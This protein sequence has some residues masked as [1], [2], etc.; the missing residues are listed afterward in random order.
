MKNTVDEKLRDMQ[1]DKQAA[2]DAAMGDDGARS[3]TLTIQELLKFFGPVGE[4]EDGQAFIWP[5]N[6]D[7][8]DSQGEREDAVP[9]L[10]PH[11]V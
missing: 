7:G 11:A 5:D 6:D 8:L 1:L 10:D 2:I 3:A 9:G 4:D